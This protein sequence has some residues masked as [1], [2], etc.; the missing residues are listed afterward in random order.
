MFL[1]I[2]QTKRKCFLCFG[3]I[4]VTLRQQIWIK[5]LHYRTQYESCARKYKTNSGVL[6]TII[7]CFHSFFFFVFVYFL[8]VDVRN[9]RTW[10]FHFWQTRRTNTDSIS[11][12]LQICTATEIWWIVFRKHSVGYYISSYIL[13][14]TYIKKM[15]FNSDFKFWKSG[16]YLFIHTF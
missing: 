5:V 14:Y 4:I 7:Y 6:D 16:K 8:T 1:I 11:S 9:E 3:K 13:N 12:A 2:Q 10:E 15:E